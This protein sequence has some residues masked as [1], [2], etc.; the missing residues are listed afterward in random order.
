[1]ADDIIREIA[2]PFQIGPSGSFDS[3]TDPVIQAIQ[4]ILSAVATTPG[5]RVMRPGYGTVV[6]GS[7]FEADDPSYMNGIITDMRTKIHAYVPEVNIMGLTLRDNSVD[8]GQVEF[9]ISFQLVGSDELHEANI[10]VG[11]TVTERTFST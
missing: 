9:R 11:G 10:A 8:D 5:E 7:L 1:M 6:Y 2:V 4:H 3:T